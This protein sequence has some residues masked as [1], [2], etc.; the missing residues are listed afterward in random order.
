MLYGAAGY[1]GALIAEQALERGHRPVLAGR[2]EPAVAALAEKLGLAHQCMS[3][4]DPV[5]LDAALANV[6]LVLNVAG[7]FLHTAAPLADAC[8]RAGVHYLDISNELQVFRALYDLHERA[9]QA[10]VAIIPGVGFG[11]V[12]TN[13]LARYVSDAVGGAKHLEV[14]TRA[15]IAQPGPGAAATRR[16]SLAYGGW[17]RHGGELEPLSLGSGITT[18]TLPD[19]P[20]QVMP[21]PTGDLE[22]AFQATGAADVVCYAPVPAPAVVG[23][24]AS[25]KD[26]AAPQPYRSSGWARATGRG[27]ATAEAFL[28]TG[29]S[30][31]FTTVAS[32]RAVEGTLA[33][34]PQ[35]ALSPAAAF[36]ADFAFTVP[37]TTRTSTMP[38]EVA[39]DERP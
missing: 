28:Q 24:Q 39:P 18:V 32:I 23:Q 4:D 17:I 29:E 16:E 6:D 22:A 11:V 31:L 8:L 30:Y 12:A 33:G 21:V 37:G 2:S 20:C 36:G 14:A 7:P 9:E 34:S 19:G 5:A 10:G 38:V 26:V 35:G 13:C 1:T 27:G 15:A 3:V 25:D